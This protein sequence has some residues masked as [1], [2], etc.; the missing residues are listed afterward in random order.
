MANQI[1]ALR[2]ILPRA[3]PGVLRPA[4]TLAIAATAIALAGNG[5]QADRGPSARVAGR[6]L[7]VTDTAHLRY[8]ESAGSA[9]LEEGS[10]TGGLPGKV[11]VR[12]TVGP[13]VSASFTISTR[14]GTLIGRGSGT[15]HSSGS[16]ASFG[17]TMSI[18]RGTGRYVHARGHGGFYGVLNRRTYALT[19]QTTGRLSY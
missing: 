10:A 1:R 7:D 13:T 16:Y 17:G 4:L 8:Q 12:F 5:A 15:L 14:S 11:K 6:T 18:G 3:A 19:V 9:L 2:P